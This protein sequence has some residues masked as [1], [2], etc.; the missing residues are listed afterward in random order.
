MVEA[1][2]G[3]PDL[4]HVPIAAKSP[5]LKEEVALGHTSALRCTVPLP[6][7]FEVGI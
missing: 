5:F 7:V 6:L 2:W 1:W 4:P 3:W